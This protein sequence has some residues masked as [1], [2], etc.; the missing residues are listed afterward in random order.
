MCIRDRVILAIGY[1]AAYT[2]ALD[3]LFVYQD[4]RNQAAA[5]VKSNLPEGS[6]IGLPTTPW[7]YTPPLLPDFG[8]VDPRDR[9]AA[10]EE[11]TDYVYVVDGRKEWNAEVLKQAAPDYAILS[12]FEYV[13]RKRLRDSDYEKYISVL[14]RDYR[15]EKQFVR[16][17]ELFGVRFPMQ[18]ELPHDMSYAS[19]DI[20][21]F[22]RSAPAGG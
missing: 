20:L 6:S 3:T 16:R 14:K 8:C 11:A 17:P 10:A 21:I 22:A 1:T 5:W 15:L 19:P 2:A 7:F 12:A 4:T 18:W 13:D 9:L